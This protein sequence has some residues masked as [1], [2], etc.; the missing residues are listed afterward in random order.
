M[1]PGDALAEGVSAAGLDWSDLAFCAISH[2]HLD[3]TG[4]LRLVPDGTPVVVQRREWDWLESGIGRRETVVPADLLDRDVQVLLVD[5]DTLLAPC[6]TA[7]DTRGHT[8]GH[9]SFRVDLAER[10]IVLACDAADPAAATWPSASRAGGRRSPAMRMLR[11]GRSS[12]SP[13]WGPSRASRSGPGTTPRSARGSAE[14][15]E[16]GDCVGL[17][18]GG[19]DLRRRQTEHAQARGSDRRVVVIGRGAG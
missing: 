13:I 6:F 16:R 17:L 18:A 19:G 11:N 3:H 1:P 9:Q 8:P 2:L 4:G 7:L 12:G 14:R 10:S 15:F 5:G